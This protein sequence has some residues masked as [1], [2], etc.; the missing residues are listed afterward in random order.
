[1]RLRFVLDDEFVPGGNYDSRIGNS[2][3]LYI[4][5]DKVLTFSR[6]IP[7]E[8]IKE[9]RE[10]VIRKT[11]ATSGNLDMVAWAV[12]AGGNNALIP[13][14][15]MG[16]KFEQQTVRLEAMTRAD[17]YKPILGDRFLSTVEAVEKID[18]PSSH[19]FQMQYGMCRIRVNIIDETGVFARPGA[20]PC[21]LLDGVMSQM[22]LQKKGVGPE[23]TVETALSCESGDNINFSTGDF[24]VLP[25]A[26]WQ[27]VSVRIV[28]AGEVVATLTVPKENLPTGAKAGAYLIFEYRI[29]ASEFLVTIDDFTHKIVIIDR[30]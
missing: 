25:S 1:M 7:Y 22:N 17:L 29:D 6:V 10:Y 19:T 30:I 9:G 20:A 4:F 13:V 3:S 15:A 11:E 21:V 12:P 8:E 28:C 14:Y 27:T 26:D 16:D 2:V 23:A 24:G 5:K 18:R